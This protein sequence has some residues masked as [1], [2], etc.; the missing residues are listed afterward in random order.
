MRAF[1]IVLLLVLCPHVLRGEEKPQVEIVLTTQKE[2]YPDEKV[3]V[4]VAIKNSGKDDVHILQAVDGAFD[5]LRQF[6]DY[7]WAVKREKIA[8]PQRNDIRRIDNFVNAIQPADLVVVKPGKEMMPHVGEV[9]DY[10]KFDTPGKYTITLTYKYTPNTTD[11]V[12]SPAL[13][14]QLQGL[15]QITAKGEVELKIV[16]FPPQVAVAEDQW[17]AAQARH[18][19]IVQFAQTVEKNPNATAVE[20][21][22]AAERLKRATAVL[23]EAKTNYEEKLAIFRKKRD[24][25][26]KKP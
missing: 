7:R 19:L 26:R 18:Q 22:A 8:V 20:R 25:E 16:P 10:F 6:V 12:S 24:E 3:A 14:K 2:I 15:P 17:K 9:G 4:K 13:L 5:G 23:A 21:D 11:K 1:S